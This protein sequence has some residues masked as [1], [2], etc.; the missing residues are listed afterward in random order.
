[1]VKFFEMVLVG[2]IVRELVQPPTITHAT[3][4]QKYHN[5]TNT[6]TNTSKD[7]PKVFTFHTNLNLYT[8]LG[9]YATS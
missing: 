6:K 3:N 1:V 9:V 7:T 2:V 5:N 8:L 4:L